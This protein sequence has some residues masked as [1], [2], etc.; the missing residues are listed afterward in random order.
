LFD[1]EQEEQIKILRMPHDLG[2]AAVL[3]AL[4]EAA[5]VP[6]RQAGRGAVSARPAWRGGTGDELRRSCA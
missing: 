1:V 3:H 6:P 5:R 2:R 4:A